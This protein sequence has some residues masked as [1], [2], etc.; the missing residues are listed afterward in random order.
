MARPLQA[1]VNLDALRANL[2]EVRAL[3]PDTQVFAVVKANAFGHACRACCR[4]WM[5]PTGWR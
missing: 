5:R 1:E 2:A 3:A 4:R